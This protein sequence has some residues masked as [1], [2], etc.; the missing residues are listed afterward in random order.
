MSVYYATTREYD[1]T[2]PVDR[3][4]TN[5]PTKN[6]FINFGTAEVSVPLP[7]SEGVQ[8]G[9]RVEKIEPP[10]KDGQGDFHDRTA[11]ARSDPKKPLVLFVHGF[12]TGLS[13]ILCKVCGA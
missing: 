8:K 5:V 4:F 3:A 6:E 2:A 1:P 7:H 11:A 9:I 12:N 13:G 10:K